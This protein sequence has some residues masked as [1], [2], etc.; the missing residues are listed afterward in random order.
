MSKTSS[1]FWSQKIEEFEKRKRST[2]GNFNRETLDALREMFDSWE[3]KIVLSSTEQASERKEIFENAS[4]IPLKRIY[5]PLDNAGNK[6]EKELGLPG[7]FPC[8][9]GVYPTM[10]RGKTWTM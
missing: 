2:N 9:R 4:G 8:T 6:Y 7:D 5:S 3:K 10:Y 1:S